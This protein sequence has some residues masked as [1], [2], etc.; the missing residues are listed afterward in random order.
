MMPLKKK[1]R[2]QI[3]LMTVLALI[4]STAMIGYAMRDGINFFRSPSEVVSEAPREDEVF[5]LGGLVKEGSI[6]APEGVR[7]D[8]VITDSNADVPVKY[9]GDNP[10][11]DLFGDN[12]GTV[13]TGTYKNGTFYAT[14]LLAKHD[15][16]Y[17]PREVIDALKDQGVYVDPNAEKAGN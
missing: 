17:M 9:V 10:R 13:A 1:R 14:E 16:N 3:L 6:T 15:E 2:I 5:R 7:F 11:P 8:F 4:L 12:Q